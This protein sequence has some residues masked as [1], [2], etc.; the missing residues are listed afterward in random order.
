MS[1][2]L[3]HSAIKS[4]MS[5]VIKPQDL[6]KTFDPNMQDAELV[7]TPIRYKHV[8]VMQVLK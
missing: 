1:A 3:S 5:K 2:G 8:I 7:F 6:F 4:A